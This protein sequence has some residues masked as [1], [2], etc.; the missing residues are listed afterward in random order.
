MHRFTVNYLK[1]DG[2]KSRWQLVN[3]G[4]FV[5]GL[6]RAMLL[7][8]LFKHRPVVDGTLPIRVSG[9]YVGQAYMWVCCDRCGVRPEPQGSLDPNMH[10]IGQRYAGPWGP[11]IREKTLAR[12]KEDLPFL[13]RPGPM[14]ESATGEVG[15]QLVIGGGLPGWGCEFKVGNAGSEH[16][17]AAS[18]HAGKLGALYLHTE[19]F[20][21][22]LVRRFNPDKQERSQSRVTGLH[23]GLDRVEWKLWVQRDDSRAAYPVS[24]AYNAVAKLLRFKHRMRVHRTL[25]GRRWWRHGAIHFNVLDKA[26]GPKLYSYT[27]VSEAFRMLRLDEGEYLLKLELKRV[28]RGRKRGFKPKPQPW[29]V[30]WSAQGKGIPDRPDHN[31]W[32]GPV[33][34][35]SVEVSR[36]AVK[37]GTWPAEAIAA[38]AVQVAGWRTRRGWDPTGLIPVSPDQTVAV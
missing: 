17:L 8:R 4:F 11:R 21:T 32:K 29:S 7:C 5:N 14:P 34:G 12:V 13:Y 1:R 18:L 3:V 23:I 33:F 28:V 15:G 16:T 20:G 38:I 36:T 37:A 30:E 27:E 9:G 24:L 6:P 35:S 31:D 22:W 19:R 2:R 25:D 10:R 26:L